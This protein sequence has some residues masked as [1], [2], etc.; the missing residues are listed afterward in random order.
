MDR[1]LPVLFDL[2]TRRWA[3]E[4]KPGVFG[5]DRKREFYSGLSAQS[6][7][8][9]MAA[10]QLAGMERARIGLPVRVRLRRHVFSVAGG[11]RAGFRALERGYR[12][13]RLVDPRIPASKAFANT[14]SWRAWG[15]TRATGEPK[16]S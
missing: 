5:W 14:I 2:H 8:A 13:A 10:F 12:A 1:L 9:R 16:P 11:L 7:G 4:G 3:E 15:G 6:A